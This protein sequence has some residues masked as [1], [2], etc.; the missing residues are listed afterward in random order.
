MSNLRLINET[1]ATSVSSLTVDNIFS[2]DFDIYKMI[3]DND[4]A[5]NN[6]MKMRLVNSSG[7]PVS[8]GGLYDYANLELNASASFG[9]DKN[10]NYNEM[11]GLYEALEG[12]SAVVYFFNPFSNSSYTFRLHQAQSFYTTN[13]PRGGKGIAVLKQTSSITGIQIYQTGSAFSYLNIRTYGLRVD[14]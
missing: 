12:N 3:I 4:N 5:G 6:V 7:S 10:T 11:R 8:A 13:Y 1:T 2:A 14:S 9:E